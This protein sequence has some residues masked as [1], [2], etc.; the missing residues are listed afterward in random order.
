MGDRRQAERAMS[1][2]RI[3]L[4]AEWQDAASACA[5]ALLD[6]HGVVRDSGTGNLAS[7]PRADECIAIISA[8]QV[9][10]VAVALPRI[11]PGQL[12]TA[13]PFAL[14]EFLLGEVA[15]SHVVPGSRL[16][17]GE[18]LLYSISK[19]RLRRFMLACEGASIRL[20]KAIPEFSLLPVQAGEWSVAWD[21]LTGFMASEHHA[22]SVLGHGSEQ[23]PPAA[24]TLKFNNASPAAV[25][26]FFRASVPTDQRAWPQWAGVNLIH[27]APDWDWRS[28]TIEAAVPNLLWGKFAP[29]ARLAEWWPRL[30]PLL[31]LLLL[32]F[33]M[34]TLGTNL[35][36]WWLAREKQQIQRT[37]DRLY[38]ETFGTEAMV[39]DAPLQ[40]R[41]SLARARHAAG[42]SDQADFLPLLDRFAAELGAL[43]GS[44]VD[45]VRYADG[46]LDVQAQLPSRST[47]DTLQR[48]LGDQGLRAQVIDVR[49]SGSAVD[50]HLRLGA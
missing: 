5:W 32:L 2:L 1:Q 13:L 44:K 4:T 28:V 40:M 24:L 26:I 49:D 35:E 22:G 50:V 9:L 45:G 37:M 8:E 47:W 29:P 27:G 33:A 18:T 39:V 11:K 14:E 6:E 34:E 17:N 20:R 41:R 7:M 15:D 36:W 10:C 3:Y 21:G 38:Q 42:L 30:R 48:R 43:P 23:L 16:A 46:Q 25:R 19:D 31:W 12:E